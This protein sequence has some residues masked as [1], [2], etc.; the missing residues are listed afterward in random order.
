MMSG[1]G[2][3]T[4]PRNT[5]P[6]RAGVRVSDLDFSALAGWKSTA[7]GHLRESGDLRLRWCNGQE[8]R[9][10]RFRGNDSVGEGAVT[11]D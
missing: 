7:P 9:G 1:T 4:P 11:Y 6:G 5:L 10:S 8:N 3:V 2:F